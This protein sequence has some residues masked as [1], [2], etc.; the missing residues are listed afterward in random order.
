MPENK[1]EEDVTSATNQDEKDDDSCASNDD[2]EENLD[3]PII[4]KAYDPFYQ[5]S[6]TMLLSIVLLLV[7]S[8]LWKVYLV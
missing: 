1:I 7:N 5:G 3:I 6:Q 2:D 8:R 4:E